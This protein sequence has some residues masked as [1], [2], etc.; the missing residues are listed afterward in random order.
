MSITQNVYSYLTENSNKKY[1]N[2]IYVANLPSSAHI[3]NSI[4]IALVP[5]LFCT[6][7]LFSSHTIP[8]FGGDES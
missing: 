8:P 4:S 7:A 1:Q 5:N 6:T 3:F 2:D